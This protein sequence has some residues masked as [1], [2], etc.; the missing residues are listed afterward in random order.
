MRLAREGASGITMVDLSNDGLAET[1]ALVSA[2]NPKCV[3]RLIS[4]DVANAADLERAFRA[5]VHEFGDLHACFNN[6]GIGER[7]K[8]HSVVDV[9]LN[10]VIQGTRL[11]VD[12]MRGKMGSAKT[13]ASDR[14]VVNVASAGGIFPMPQAPVYSATKAAVVL[15][16]QS[17][18]HL[19]KTHGVR[20]N[21]V[22]P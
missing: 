15:Y 18:A 8:W 9:N 1:S 12:D 7:A 16:S 19:H 10:A 20:V 2:A 14:V 13:T 5:H 21:A 17:L 3:T 11:A 22:S 4:A 6:A